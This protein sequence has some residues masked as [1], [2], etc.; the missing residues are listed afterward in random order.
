MK[1]YTKEKQEAIK[2]LE[3]FE[4]QM[5]LIK[6]FPIKEP[7]QQSKCAPYNIEEPIQYS[8]SFFWN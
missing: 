2:D 1:K 8:Q 4:K 7:I 3:E 6:Q 5:E